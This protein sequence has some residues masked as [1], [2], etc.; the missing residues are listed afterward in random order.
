VCLHHTLVHARHDLETLR[1]CASCGWTRRSNNSGLSLLDVDAMFVSACAG[2]NAK[3]GAQRLVLAHKSYCDAWYVAHAR[4]DAW[5]S[6]G[7]GMAYKLPLGNIRDETLWG[8]RESTVGTSGVA[9]TRRRV[10]RPWQLTVASEWCGASLG[11]GEAVEC[12]VYL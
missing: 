12:V 5:G 10:E 2:K 11:G 1:G 7:V 3:N 6:G 4:V 9:V 8:N